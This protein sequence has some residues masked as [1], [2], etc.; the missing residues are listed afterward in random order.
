[1][2]QAWVWEGRR[3]QT[4]FINAVVTLPKDEWGFDP[5]TLAEMRPGCWDVKQRV[6]DM[7]ANGVLASMCFPSFPGMG[8]AFFGLEDDK[9]LALAC[10]QAYNDWHF[11]EWCAS[12]PGRFIPLGITPTWDP[13]V[14]AAEVRRMARKGATAMTFVED[15]DALGAPS[16]H[17]GE[18][19]PL[20]AACVDEGVTLAI[21]IGS[22]ATS[23]LGSPM[24]PIDVTVTLPCWYLLPCLANFMW[25]KSLQK[26][27]DLKIALSEGGTSWIPGFLDRM[28]R[29]YSHQTWTGADL[30]GLTPTETFRRNFLSCFVSDPSGLL[31]RDRIGIDNIAYEIDYPHSDCTWPNSSDELYEHL[32]AAKCTD[33]EIDKIT[34]ENA[35]QWLSYDPFKHAPREE[36]TVGALKARA[37]DVDTRIRS[38]KEYAADYV[39]QHG[40]IG[41]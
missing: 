10:V 36:V 37:V 8:G 13:T 17:S 20:F 34:H 4:S 28:E 5:G 6:R 24:Q 14:A 41:G 38:R 35:A 40:S 31:L 18:W 16:L 32:E 29:H 30:G 27:P 19:D 33:A 3:V 21:H 39:A 22:A 1:M 25:S 9:E 15:I 23:A 2:T 7:D 26:F 11:D 12:A